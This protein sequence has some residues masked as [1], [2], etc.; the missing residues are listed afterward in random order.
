M[1][2]LFAPGRTPAPRTTARLWAAG[3]GALCALAG[4]FA[5]GTP[6]LVAGASATLLV[7]AFL[8]T[9]VVPLLVAQRSPE[10]AGPGMIVLLLTYTLRLVLLLVAFVLL[11]RA[12]FVDERWLGGTVVVVALTWVVAQ[13]AY[14]V[15]AS[16]TEL[17]VVPEKAP[18]DDPHTTG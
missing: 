12:G 16:R 13:V 7:V 11:G 9:G 15:K 6:A 10:Y 2:E 1:R 5:A 8:S 18:S 3:A 4:W 17:T 14:A